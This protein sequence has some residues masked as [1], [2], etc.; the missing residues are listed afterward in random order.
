MT[1]I[2]YNNIFQEDLIWMNGLGIK[3]KISEIDHQHLSNILWFNEVMH[4]WTRENKVQ[5][6]LGCQLAKRFPGETGNGHDVW[7]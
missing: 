6:M 7:Y 1:N 2:E 3:K 4:G 5:F